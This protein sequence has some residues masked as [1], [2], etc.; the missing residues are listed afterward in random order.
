GMVRHEVTDDTQ[1][2]LFTTEGLIRALLHGRDTVAAVHE[3]YL[4]W[5]DTQDHP[6]PPPADDGFRTGRLR[7]QTWLYARRGPGLTCLSG[8]R[9]GVR[10]AADT[11]PPDRTGPVNPHSK[12]CGAVV[13]SAPF[14]FVSLRF[15]HAARC[16]RITHGHPTAADA[17]GALALIIG[18]LAH[19]EDL[20]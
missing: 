10:P 20:R 5:L 15:E 8:L 11:D 12:G 19:G 6:A 3:A 2:T 18:G 14:G 9:S 4:R 13:R 7:E 16:A 1:L 17:A